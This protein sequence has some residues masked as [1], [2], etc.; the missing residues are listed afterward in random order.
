[1][2]RKSVGP[3]GDLSKAVSA[4]IRADLGRLHWTQTD[5]A[6][7]AG[8]STNY[9]NTRLRDQAPLNLNDIEDFSHALGRSCDDLLRVAAE[10]FEHRQHQDHTE[11]N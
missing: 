8:K 9:T 6:K 10:H 2:G 3:A 1:M 4:E 5:L 7:R 11:G